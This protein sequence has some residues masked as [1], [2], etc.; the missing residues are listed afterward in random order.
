MNDA[1]V[2]QMA[3]QVPY[4]LAEPGSAKPCLSQTIAFENSRFLNDTEKEEN[5]KSVRFWAVRLVYLSI[6]YHQ[7][8]P[9]IPEVETIYRD[10]AATQKCLAEREAR[11]IGRYDYEC[12]KKKFIV[13]GF[14]NNILG[15]NIRS[16]AVT[17]FLAGLASDHIILFVNNSPVGVGY[18]YITAPWLLAS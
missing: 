6:L 4:M 1:F 7:H 13:A 12:P 9:A 10:D 5:A 16:G 18:R 8:S 15:A 14:S 3:L 11:G 2:K 17:Q